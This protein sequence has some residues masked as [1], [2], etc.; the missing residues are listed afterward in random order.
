VCKCVLY[1]CHRV[2]TQLK[3]N[4][5][6]Q[7]RLQWLKL[8]MCSQHSKCFWKRHDAARPFLG[9]PSADRA[10]PAA[11]MYCVK[12]LWWQVSFSLQFAGTWNVCVEVGDSFF[13]STTFHCGPWLPL[14]CSSISQ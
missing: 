5:S 3:L 9:G 4:I 12:G 1:Y 6:Y 14:E 10:L 11:A 2:A 7:K 8:W 13:S